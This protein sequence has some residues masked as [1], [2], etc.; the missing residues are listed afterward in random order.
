MHSLFCDY[1]VISITQWADM[2]YGRAGKSWPTGHTGYVNGTLFALKL[3]TPEN[4]Y[5]IF[6]FCVVSYSQ[7]N[8]LCCAFTLSILGIE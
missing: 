1:V 5:L 3:L 8:E 2:V 7:L 6:C 4:I